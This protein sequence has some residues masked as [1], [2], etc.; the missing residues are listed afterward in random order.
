MDAK[1]VVCVVGMDNSQVILADMANQILLAMQANGYTCPGVSA[2][3]LVQAQWKNGVFINGQTQV[4]VDLLVPTGTPDNTVGTAVA[5]AI[6]ILDIPIC[7]T[8]TTVSNTTVYDTVAAPTPGPPNV[9]SE[10]TNGQP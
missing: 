9:S 10:P 6:S 1:K 7:T 8:P 4:I 2:T 5:F 3:V